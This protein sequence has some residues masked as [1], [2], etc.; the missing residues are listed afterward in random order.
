MPVSDT[1]MFFGQILAN[2]EKWSTAVAEL[3]K[4]GVFVP[5]F[6]SRAISSGYF[7]VF[8]KEWTN[9]NARN[10]H[11]RGEVFN[12][13][14][15]LE[16]KFIPN[17]PSI[18][19]NL[20]DAYAEVSRMK[21]GRAINQISSEEAFSPES[22]LSPILW[23]S[24]VRADGTRKSR[25]VFHSKFNCL[26]SKPKLSMPDIAEECHVVS[27]FGELVKVDMQDCYVG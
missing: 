8:S 19:E 12:N 1:I 21:E 6:L 10:L 4:S 9:F 13:L 2:K 23:V 7:D 15:D 17:S 16:N 14:Q 22:V 26:Y 27:E 18:E 24:K 11:F 5:P 3:K 20:V 25:L